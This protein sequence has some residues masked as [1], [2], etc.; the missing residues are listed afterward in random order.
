[1]SRITPSRWLA[2]PR[3][4]AAR[5]QKTNLGLP[6][7]KARKSPGI[8]RCDSE[9]KLEYVLAT[10]C[11]RLQG[12]HL[13]GQHVLIVLV[14]H[15]NVA[16]AVLGSEVSYPQRYPAPF[17]WH[18]LSS[19]SRPRDFANLLT[20]AVRERRYFITVIVSV[21][22]EPINYDESSD[23]SDY[24]ASYTDRLTDTLSHGLPIRLPNHAHARVALWSSSKAS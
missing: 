14:P 24:C 21:A 23:T 6:Q 19:H 17:W 22:G 11:Y 10:V 9:R 3:A 1:M 20:V 13:G 12:E 8:V 5:P 2:E 15:A 18:S 7:P 16:W 4:T